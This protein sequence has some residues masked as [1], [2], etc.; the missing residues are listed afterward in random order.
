MIHERGML[1]EREAL[2]RIVSVEPGGALHF[3]ADAWTALYED[4][5]INAA[6]IA[7]WL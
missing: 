7:E 5:R 2:G 6:D 4:L 3:R 1:H